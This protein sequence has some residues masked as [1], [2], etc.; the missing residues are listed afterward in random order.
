M[1][2]MTACGTEPTHYVV[3]LPEGQKR[4][5]LELCRTHLEM[6]HGLGEC[7]VTNII[8]YGSLDKQWAV[9]PGGKR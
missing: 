6:A 2:D 7:R 5:R 9:H 3:I 1:C 8:E 4:M